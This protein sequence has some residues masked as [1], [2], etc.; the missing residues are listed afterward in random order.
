MLIALCGCTIALLRDTSLDFTGTHQALGDTYTRSTLNF[1]PSTQP[2]SRLSMTVL[3]GWSALAS[4][5]S[6]FLRRAEEKN[7]GT[8]IITITVRILLLHDIQP[9]LLIISAP[10]GT[11]H[12]FIT[13]VPSLSRNSLSPRPQECE[14]ERSIRNIRSAR[15]LVTDSRYDAVSVVP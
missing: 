2:H 6:N 7:R 11:S 15:F 14:N 3:L 4:S 8:L 12:Y 13:A 10:T 5:S 1:S 9:E